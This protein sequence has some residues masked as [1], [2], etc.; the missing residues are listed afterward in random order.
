MRS[1]TLQRSSQAIT[2][3]FIRMLSALLDHRPGRLPI[4]WPREFSFAIA[5]K[6]IPTVT[7]K[8]AHLAEVVH[9]ISGVVW[10]LNFLKRSASDVGEHLKCLHL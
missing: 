7:Q 8:K 5:I 6:L 9:T 4:F 3:V 1:D 2:G 10:D